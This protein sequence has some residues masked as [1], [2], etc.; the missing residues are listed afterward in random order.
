LPGGDARG[1]FVQ[2]TGQQAHTEGLQGIAQYPLN[3]GCRPPL[4]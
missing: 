2:R 4:L 1:K 3:L